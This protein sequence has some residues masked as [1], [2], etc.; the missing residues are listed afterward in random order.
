[1]RKREQPSSRGAEQAGSRPLSR[2]KKPCT[3]CKDSG[4][5]GYTVFCTYHDRLVE[6]DVIGERRLT[7]GV[8]YMRCMWCG[9]TGKE[10]DEALKL[11]E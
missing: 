10:I 3:V 1:M 9:G 2:K 5:P 6:T 11:E 4:R 7:S 8:E